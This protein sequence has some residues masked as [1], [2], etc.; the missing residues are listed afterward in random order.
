MGFEGSL[1]KPS[2]SATERKVW[3]MRF[4]KNSK[5]VPSLKLT[6]QSRGWKMILFWGRLKGLFLGRLLLLV[7]WSVSFLKEKMRLGFLGQLLQL[8]QTAG[9]LAIFWIFFV[10]LYALLDVI[11]SPTIPPKILLFP[12]QQYP[13]TTKLFILLFVTACDCDPLKGCPLW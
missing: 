8:V 10:L 3:P 1:K 13:S 4:N 9:L 6:V 5:R 2:H 12:H 7:V 11:L